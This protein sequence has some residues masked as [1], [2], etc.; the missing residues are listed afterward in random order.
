MGQILVRNLDDEVVRALKA[1]AAGAEKS[2]EQYVRDVLA[3]A[4]RPTK[5]ELL[6]QMDAMRECIKLP[7]DA[8]PYE[9]ILDEM[10]AEQE[11]RALRIADLAEDD[12]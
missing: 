3:D 4:A 5:A 2:L 1:K 9:T 12:E 11:E 10:K 6:E 8:P 7:P